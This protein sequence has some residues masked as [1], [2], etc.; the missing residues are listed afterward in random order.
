MQIISDEEN[1]RYS[2]WLIDSIE[3]PI[4]NPIDYQHIYAEAVALGKEVM[5]RK[6]NHEDGWVFWL[7]ADD[8]EVMRE[9]NKM[10]MISNYM[11]DQILRLY[12]VPE[13]GV[14]SAY[15]KFRY[16]AEIMER[17]GGCPALSRNFYQQNLASVMLRLGFKKLHKSKG[18]GWIVIEKDA[19]E[20]NTDS[21]VSPRE[22]KETF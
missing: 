9:H 21:I 1:R 12:R 3:S 22:M 15:V 8:I 18:N 7:T 17:I 13:E 20:I 10:F 11:E 16:S 5:K 14:D 2:P 19:G 6:K 4:D